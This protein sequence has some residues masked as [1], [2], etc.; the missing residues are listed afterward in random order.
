MNTA[1]SPSKKVRFGP[2]EANLLTQELYKFGTRLRLPNQSFQVLSVLLER[3]GEMVTREQLQA[4]LWPSDTFVEYDQGLNAA[5]NRLR[6]VL[7]DSAEKPRFIETLPRRGYRFIAA[8]EAPQ[9]DAALDSQ[10]ESGNSSPQSLPNAASGE[11]L[12]SK[13][14]SLPSWADVRPPSRG[15]HRLLWIL[16]GIVSI[17][18]LLAVVVTS[19][20]M[21]LRKATRTENLSTERVVP[22]TSL[23]GQEVAPSFSPDGSQ[24]VFAWKGDSDKGFDL[25]V[26]TIGS[27]RVLRLTDHPA[28]W[29]SPAWSPDG[30]QIAF[31]RWAPDEKG[32]F[33]IPALGGP[34]RKLSSAD[35][36]YEPFMQISWSPDAQSIAFWSS[37]EAAG[38]HVFLLPLDTLKPRILGSDLHCLDAAGPAFSP[39]G[40]NVALICT[41]SIAVYTIYTVPVSGGASQLVASMMGYPRGLTWSGDGTR[42]LFSND[43]GNGGDLWQVS[44]DG[45][46]TKVPFGDGGTFPAAASR[47]DRLAFARGSTTIDVWRLDLAA[48]QPGDSAT[49]LIFSTLIQRDPQY[50]PDGTKIVFD[51]NRSG[52]FEIWLTDANGN[53]PVQ[54]TSFNGPETGAARWCSDGRRIA[55]DSRASGLSAI[56]VEDVQERLPR[57]IQ[58]NVENVALPTW[59][60]DCRWLYASDGKT[61]LYRIPYSGGNAT[62]VTEHPS[63]YTFVAGDQLFFNVKKPAGVELWSMPADGGA[64]TRVNSVPALTYSDAW[65]VTPAGIYY[66]DSGSAT[67]RFFDFAHEATKQ[68]AKLKHAPTPAGGLG[69]AISPDRRWL[70]YTQTDDE[71][72]DIMLVEHFR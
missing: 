14:P 37:E 10:N 25:Y 24:V 38:S 50:S 58:T 23:P 44:M 33:V 55:F 40:K 60:A 42:I 5:V 39:D 27:E 18:V 67:I 65:A 53:N 15:S 54:L 16:L 20:L 26:K 45:T 64:E 35:F 30:R 63:Y 51:S 46:L 4:R 9:I 28:N 8:V 1:S 49:K 34:E 66:T 52:S 21:H 72:S 2:F 61:S 56:Y 11:G 36:W 12:E 70:L 29:I 22:F 71:Q 57:Q 13:T 32:I 43:S 59:S 3:P 68:V 6:E 19:V 69:L 62:R 47:G 31:S 48:P 17:S 41:S 7:G